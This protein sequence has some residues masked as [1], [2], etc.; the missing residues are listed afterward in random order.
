M[1][2]SVTAMWPVNKNRSRAILGVKGLW[3]FGCRPAECVQARFGREERDGEQAT[4]S[5][6]QRRDAEHDRLA[7]GGGGGVK[8]RCPRLAGRVGAGGRHQDLFTALRACFLSCE[9]VMPAV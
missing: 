2:S 8:A 3:Q 4:G 9:D 5:E 1:V 7:V 6:H